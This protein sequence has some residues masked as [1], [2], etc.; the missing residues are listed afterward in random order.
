MRAMNNPAPST[1][2]PSRHPGV[3]GRLASI[4]RPSLPPLGEADDATATDREMM[5]RAITL[6][7][8]AAE[9]GEVPVGA[10]VYETGTSRVLAEAH[11]TR[12]GDHDPTAHAELVAVREAA[13]AL[14][15]WRLNACTLVVTLEPCPMCA[16]MLVNARLGRVVYGTDDP[17]AGACRSLFAITTDP[18][19]NHRCEVIAGVEAKVCSQIL[20]EFF[21]QRRRD[22]R[23]D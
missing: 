14:G 10:V 7:R 16:G 20:R 4:F 5:A 8:R 11:N 17:K 12:E 2:D 6:A 23:R 21:K 3:L 19:L 15:D 18:R 22:K 1:Q 13:R 9:Q